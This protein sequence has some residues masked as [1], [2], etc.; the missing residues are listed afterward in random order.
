MPG[1]VPVRRRVRELRA[2]RRVEDPASG[3]RRA[4]DR[5]S[6]GAHARGRG[7]LGRP[8]LSASAA[9]EGRA[10][11]AETTSRLVLGAEALLRRLGAAPAT[12]TAAAHGGD[13]F[14]AALGA[15]L[16]AAYYGLVHGEVA[17]TAKARGTPSYAAWN[18]VVHFPTVFL[19]IVCLVA[20]DPRRLR[21]HAPPARSVA[22]LAALYGLAYAAHVTRVAAASAKPP[23]AFMARLTTARRRVA[24]WGGGVAVAVVPAT[25]GAAALVAAL[26]ET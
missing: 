10:R 12:L 1:V 14:V 22:C 25:L 16:W 24:F 18:H 3:G 9:S 7:R 8:L 6:H 17:R 26:A 20:K 15:V 2:A 13:A 21:A 4:E 11:I 23:Y 19:P 5:I